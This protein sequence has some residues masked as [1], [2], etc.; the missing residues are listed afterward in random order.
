MQSYLGGTASSIAIGRAIEERPD[1]FSAAVIDAP[2]FDMLRAETTEFGKQSIPEF[3]TV[4]NRDG[5]NA[6]LAMS[7]YAHVRA[8]AN[9][10]P[11]LVRSFDHAYQIGDQWQA[12]KMVARWQ[13]AT[14]RT[15]SAYLDVVQTSAGN[16][17]NATTLRADALHFFAY[18]NSRAEQR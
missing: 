12:A 10:P 1:L 18:E 16:P 5:F 2:S 15:D 9:Y 4:T 11:I 7:P 3:G 6:L 13:A 17:R 14:G 8:G